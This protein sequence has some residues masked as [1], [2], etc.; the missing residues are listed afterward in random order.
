MSENPPP[1]E[2]DIV[3][4]TPGDF[5]KFRKAKQHVAGQAD[6]WG[7]Y[8][9]DEGLN[10]AVDHPD[11]YPDHWPATRQR[12]ENA[13]EWR[14]QYNDPEIFRHDLNR[15]WE[16][17]VE[18]YHDETDPD[19]IGLYRAVN[20][21]LDHTTCP[22]PASRTGYSYRL[23]GYATEY[24]YN[25]APRPLDRAERLELQLLVN[26]ALNHLEKRTH[27]ISGTSAMDFLGSCFRRND[28]YVAI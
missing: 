11:D 8:M 10:H 18:H 12:L 7:I 21:L 22:D 3:A 1:L 20:A 24:R 17:Y 6:H 15:I 9:S 16:H 14:R 2:L 5:R 27:Q 13:A 19:A 26:D 23:S 25:R 28:G 4:I